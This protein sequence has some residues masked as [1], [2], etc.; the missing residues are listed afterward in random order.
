MA[1]SLAE[2]PDRPTGPASLAVL[3]YERLASQGGKIS[4]A[5]DRRRL[6]EAIPPL[7]PNV[8]PYIHRL[9]RSYKEK[10]EDDAIKLQCLSQL[11]PSG[12]TH[13]NIKGQ[14]GIDEIMMF[15]REIYSLILPS[16]FDVTKAMDNSSNHP[17][18]CS[19]YLSKCLALKVPTPSHL[20]DQTPLP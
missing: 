3:E 11:S 15:T 10:R 5:A 16:A 12:H 2:F 1:R 4:M 6:A 13:L 8:F 14:N 7:P 9:D 18:G 20:Q 19:S 17:C